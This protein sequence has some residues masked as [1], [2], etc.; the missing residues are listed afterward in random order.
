MTVAKT[1]FGHQY[2]I[3]EKSFGSCHSHIQNAMMAIL[4]QKNDNEDAKQLFEELSELAVKAH[5]LEYTCSE[6]FK[7][8]D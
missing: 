8:N 1:G 5:E 7:L 4:D 6:R 3:E 2:R